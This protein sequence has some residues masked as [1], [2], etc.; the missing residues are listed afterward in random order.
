MKYKLDNNILNIKNSFK[1]RT[2]IRKKI[3]K[4]NEKFI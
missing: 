1:K 3:I 4:I 2:N